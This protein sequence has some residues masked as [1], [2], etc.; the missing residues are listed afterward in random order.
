MFNLFFG[1]VDDNM[2]TMAIAFLI[3]CFI[4]YIVGDKLGAKTD[5]WDLEAKQ[6]KELQ[7]KQQALELSKQKCPKCGGKTF[8]R[9]P[10]ETV[11]ERYTAA[12]GNTNEI[13]GTKYVNF[14]SQCNVEAL[15]RHYF[16]N[17]NST[18]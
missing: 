1:W 13:R 14:C 7:K 9:Q 12:W 3:L 5:K 11:V 10:V 4:I 2:F 18:T 15:P 8:Y 16:D 6:R 17:Q